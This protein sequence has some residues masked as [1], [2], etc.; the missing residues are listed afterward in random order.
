MKKAMEDFVR[1]SVWACVWTTIITSVR[2][3]VDLLRKRKRTYR[4]YKIEEKGE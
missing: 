2:I 3:I 4:T 1:V